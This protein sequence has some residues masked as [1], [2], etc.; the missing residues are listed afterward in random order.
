MV[1]LS[2]SVGGRQQSTIA[3]DQWP[4]RIYGI[5]QFLS[6]WLAVA[7]LIDRPAEPPD[8]FSC[9]I[10]INTL[11]DLGQDSLFILE[12]K[13]GAFRKSS[14]RGSEMGVNILETGK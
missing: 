14:A 8:D 1:A 6:R 9:R 5:Q 12:I 7:E 4:T 3:E 13:D 10:L 2:G 11:F